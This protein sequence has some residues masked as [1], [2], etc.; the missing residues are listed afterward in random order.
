MLQ[1]TESSVMLAFLHDLFTVL[2]NV[3]MDMQIPVASVKQLLGKLTTTASP[4]QIPVLDQICKLALKFV[5][6]TVL[7]LLRRHT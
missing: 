2:L 1:H 3:T 4:R 7:I 5:T 6:K